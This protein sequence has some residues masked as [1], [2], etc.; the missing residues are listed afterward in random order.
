MNV[1]IK[2][3]WTRQKWSLNKYIIGSLLSSSASSFWDGKLF[4]HSRHINVSQCSR[5]VFSNFDVI[6]AEWIICLTSSSCPLGL[7]EFIISSLIFYWFPWGIF[8]HACRPPP[9]RSETVLPGGFLTEHWTP[10]LPSL[11]CF[12]LQRSPADSSQRSGIVINLSLPVFIVL[13]F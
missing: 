11:L 7:R 5:F 8:F 3:L 6:G 9:G 10:C 13:F 4:S 2:C 12:A 1:E